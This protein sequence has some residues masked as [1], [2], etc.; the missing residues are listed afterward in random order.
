MSGRRA[1]HIFFSIDYWRELEK[2]FADSA[3][4]Y[5]PDDTTRNA[6]IARCRIGLMKFLEQ[7]AEFGAAKRLPQRTEPGRPKLDQDRC[8]YVWLAVEVR[9]AISA[10]SGQGLKKVLEPIFRRNRPWR[11]LTNL[12]G[13]DHIEIESF[14]IADRL[15]RQGKK[16]LDA[17]PLLAK[18]WAGHLSFA[19][20]NAS[21]RVA[22]PPQKSPG[23]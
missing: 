5:A 3:T 20:K 7:D 15:H 19:I 18:T 12:A 21:K 4:K 22:R 2:K 11:V 13:G 1:T 9:K 17:N 8:L 23:K 6:I 16:L 10:N 14:D